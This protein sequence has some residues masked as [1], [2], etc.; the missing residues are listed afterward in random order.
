MQ[1]NSI[2]FPKKLYFSN[3]NNTQN[4]AANNE[5]GL[6]YKKPLKIKGTRNYYLKTI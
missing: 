1:S 3:A 2:H 6:G 5:P 4:V